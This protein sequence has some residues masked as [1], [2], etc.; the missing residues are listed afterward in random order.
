MPDVKLSLQADVLKWDNLS[1][2]DML[3]N[4]KLAKIRANNRLNIILC[5]QH[6]LISFSRA[7]KEEEK[8]SSYMHLPSSSAL[9][10]T[11]GWQSVSSLMEEELPMLI[12]S[13]AVMDRLS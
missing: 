1:A 8:T 9:T 6:L 5:P 13:S 7:K 11:N 12:K 4:L 2:K 3:E 10:T